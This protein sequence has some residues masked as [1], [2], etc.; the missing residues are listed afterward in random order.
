MELQSERPLSGQG[1][2]LCF[3][4]V[5]VWLSAPAGWLAAILALVL[6]DHRPIF[7]LPRYRPRCGV[8]IYI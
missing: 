8:L 6:E 4:S 3:P 1:R 7:G 5:L 2:M